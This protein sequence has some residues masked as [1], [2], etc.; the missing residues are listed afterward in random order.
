MKKRKRLVVAA[1]SVALVLL[2]ALVG[3]IAW[4]NRIENQFPY[5][6]EPHAERRL[7]LKNVELR[8]TGIDFDAPRPHD[9]ERHDDMILV[10]AKNNSPNRV[11]YRTMDGAIDYFYQGSWH[12]VLIAYPPM[13]THDK[14]LEG[15]SETL[16][17][18]PVAQGFFARDGKYRLY[19]KNVGTCEMDIVGTGSMK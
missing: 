15:N 18:I 11:A 19:L 1:V 5:W 9:A 14:Y 17:K 12:L 7:E 8:F 10:L 2:T 13:E 6:E 16:L 3:G 4:E